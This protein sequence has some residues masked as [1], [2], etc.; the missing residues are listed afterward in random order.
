MFP[1]L[2]RVTLVLALLA[3]GRLSA[4]SRDI[5]QAPRQGR[6]AICRPETLKR[7]SPVWF[8]TA[9]PTLP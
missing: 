1:Q 4:A 7:L 3:A 8:L 9:F 6:Q 5:L 2:V